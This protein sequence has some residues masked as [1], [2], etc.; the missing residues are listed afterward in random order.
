MHLK[1]MNSYY[2]SRCYRSPLIRNNTIRRSVLFKLGVLISALSVF[3]FRKL[4]FAM[5]T[6]TLI[7]FITTLSRRLREY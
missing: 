5:V 3:L 2:Y 7:L 4:A 1:R 6:S